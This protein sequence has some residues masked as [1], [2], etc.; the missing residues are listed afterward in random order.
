MIEDSKQP[1]PLVVAVVLTWN[2]VEMTSRCIES[3]L[4]NT[5]PRMNIV[6][7]DNGSNPPGCP[8]L[9][10]RFPMIEPVQ[11]SENTGF[12]GGCNRGIERAL[13]LGADY[14]FLLNN[15]TIVHE[16]AIQELV[17]AMESRLDAGIASALLLYPGKEK[18]T[19]F[20]RA[21]IARDRAYIERFQEIEMLSDEHRRVFEGNFAPA[22]AVMFRPKALREVGLFDESLF[23][24]WEDYDLCCRFNDAGWRVITVGTAEVVHAHGQTTGR[25]SPFIT[26]YFARNRLICLFRHGKLRGILRHS[27]TILRQYYWQ[28]RA[29]G[30]SNW[31]AHRALLLG[32][33]DFMLGVRGKGHAPSVRRDRKGLSSN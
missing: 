8:I 13:E 22:C 15:D 20:V 4:E 19:Q 14:V 30:W 12:T 2:D 26:Y 29:Y 17:D 23:T 10:T 21:E 25:I 1:R 27:F 9:K 18:R 16:R 31:P 5:F 33:I 7:V 6:V 32:M 3:V 24:N 28:M 11:L